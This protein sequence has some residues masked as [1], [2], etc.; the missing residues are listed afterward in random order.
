DELVA[1]SLRA[2][3]DLLQISGEPTLID[4]CPYPAAIPQFYLGH[5][6]RIT[7][8]RECVATVPG[9]HLAGN[10]LDGVSI[11][12][13]VRLAKQVAHEIVRDAE[14][15]RDNRALSASEGSERNS[16][17]PTNGV[18]SSRAPAAETAA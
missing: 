17:D 18:A 11:N 9:L 2:L 4:V 1:T 12:D 8:L 6:Q 13:C 15:K 7:R 5:E 3:R 10:Y 14:S 16:N